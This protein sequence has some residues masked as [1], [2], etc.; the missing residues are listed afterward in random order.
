MLTH[1][2]CL[3]TL[4]YQS[5]ICLNARNL[6]LYVGDAVPATIVRSD[7]RGSGGSALFAG[8]RP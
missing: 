4:T 5:S 8:P 1:L 2:V 6:K 3:H 7:A